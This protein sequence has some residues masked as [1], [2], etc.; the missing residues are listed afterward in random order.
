MTTPWEQS[1]QRLQHLLS[2]RAIFGLDVEEGAELQELLS[3]GWSD[4]VDA[5]DQTA[6]TCCLGLGIDVTDP[7][8]FSLQDRIRAD[9]KRIMGCEPR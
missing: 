2:D 1:Q 9:A 3:D 5:M 8:P 4:D 7:L 6:A